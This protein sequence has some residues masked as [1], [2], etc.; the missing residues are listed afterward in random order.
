MARG[1]S[2]LSPSFPTFLSFESQRNHI[3]AAIVSLGRFCSPSLSAVAVFFFVK[4]GRR[5]RRERERERCCFFF[6]AVRL[7]GGLL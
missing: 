4:L 1:Y 3:S 6:F 7:V 2:S 5:E